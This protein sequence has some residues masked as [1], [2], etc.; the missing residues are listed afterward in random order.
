[1]EVVSLKRL[2]FAWLLLLTV[3][4]T[5]CG[6]SAR[7]QRENHGTEVSTPQR[8]SQPQKDISSSPAPT[9]N[10]KDH[11]EP[12]L[13]LSIEALRGLLFKSPQD[14]RIWAEFASAAAKQRLP[15]Q[16]RWVA[17]RSLAIEPDQPGPY[18]SLAVACYADYGVCTRSDALQYLQKANEMASTDLGLKFDLARSYELAGQRDQALALYQELEASGYG[19]AIGARYSAEPATAHD[20]TGD[21]VNEVVAV[22]GR[23]VKVS[24]PGGD[25]LLVYEP[26]GNAPV[27]ARF[28]WL[29]SQLPSLWVQA[30][31][32]Q[33]SYDA[34]FVWSPLERKVRLV[35]EESSK[36]VF[37]DSL[38]GHLIKTI[39]IRPGVASGTRYAFREGRFE[40]VGE[41]AS[42][43]VGNLPEAHSLEHLEILLAWGLE[44]PET[45]PEFVQPDAWQALVKAVSP[46]MGRDGE[47]GLVFA[48]DPDTNKLMLLILSDG[49]ELLRAD[50]QL[51][52]DEARGWRLETLD[53]DK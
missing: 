25:V 16:A 28:I 27:E 15:Y 48:L 52:Q 22:Q 3:L 23:E 42:L 6:P 8:P 53:F 50:A 30:A 20:L 19:P 1:M 32:E 9:D 5:G 14:A 44:T 34:V 38:H 17:K 43:S 35:W 49:E 10:P 11:A 18:H 7:V 46:R 51:N 31:D 29:R 26:P 13:G 36:R 12:V 37:Y 45:T 21:G 33:G 4:L 24:T 41:V 39:S 40:A 2:T 47:V